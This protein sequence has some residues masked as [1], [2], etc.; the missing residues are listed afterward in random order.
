LTLDDGIDRLSQNVGDELPVNLC[1]IPEEHKT[2]ALRQ[3]PEIRTVTAPWNFIWMWGWD[4]HSE[5]KVIHWACS[6]TKGWAR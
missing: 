2:R 6:R 5:W 3:K 1:N 4:P